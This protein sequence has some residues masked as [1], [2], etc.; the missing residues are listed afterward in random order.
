MGP[1]KRID[2][3]RLSTCARF[4]DL[5]SDDRLNSIPIGVSDYSIKL[6]ID[7]LAKYYWMSRQLDGATPQSVQKMSC[8]ELVL[9]VVKQQK[10]VPELVTCHEAVAFGFHMHR[11]SE[12]VGIKNYVAS[13]LWPLQIGRLCQRF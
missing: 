7:A 8:D 10:L 2:D 5:K 12:Q 4:R 11:K 6:G 1:V 3:M 9:F 13:A